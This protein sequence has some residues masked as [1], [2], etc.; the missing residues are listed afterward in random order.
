MS[1]SYAAR[2]AWRYPAKVAVITAPTGSAVPL[3]LL[4][5]HVAQG[6]TDDD[7]M[8]EA[9]GLAAQEWAEAYLGRALLTQTREAS[10]DGTPGGVVLLPE[11][12]TSLTS[13]KTYD[14]AAAATTVTTATYQLDTASPLPRLILRDGQFWP[15]SLRDVDS[16]VVRYVCGWT[17]YT[18]PYAVRQAVQ[19]LVA[20]WYEQR[21]PVAAG[22]YTTVPMGIEALLM[23]YRVRTGAA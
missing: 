6:V 23:P 5:A 15:T 14:D 2:C 4:R 1:V 18:L 20:H 13:V 7:A 12:I 3:D 21:Q 10:Y 8:L 19:V 22:N 11:P 9:I 17:A 16:L